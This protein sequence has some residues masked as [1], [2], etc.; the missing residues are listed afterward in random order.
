MTDA[1]LIADLILIA[2]TIHHANGKYWMEPGTIA[3]TPT[4]DLIHHQHTPPLG[5][6]YPR[7]DVREIS[8]DQPSMTNGERAAPSE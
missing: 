3:M 1:E 7:R 5:D 8:A 4:G 2:G 6:M